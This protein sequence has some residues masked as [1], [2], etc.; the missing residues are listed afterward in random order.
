M[1]QLGDSLERLVTAIAALPDSPEPRRVLADLLLEQGH[2]LGELIQLELSGHFTRRWFDLV[3][4]H[5]PAFVELVAP[6]A[7]A[8]W[9]H[10]GLPEVAWYRSGPLL[11]APPS[12]LPFLRQVFVRASPGHGSTVLGHAALRHASSLVLACDGPTEPLDG[13]PLPAAL[14]AFT[15]VDADWRTLTSALATARPTLRRLRLVT[16][17]VE[18]VMAAVRAVLD[19]RLTLDELEL[20]GFALEKSA[21]DLGDAAKALGLS[22]LVL[23]AVAA[24]PDDLWR[25]EP[26]VLLARAASPSLA[27]VLLG[28]GVG[29]L[30]SNGVSS[31]RWHFGAPARDV[32]G[33]RL[34]AH[35]GSDF[36]LDAFQTPQ[37]HRLSLRP[38]PRRGDDPLRAQAFVR[39]VRAARVSSAAVFPQVRD[40]GFVEATPQLTLEDVRGPLLLPSCLKQPCGPSAALFRAAAALADGLGEALPGQLSADA[41]ALCDD[42]RL[43]AVSP[44]AVPPWPRAGGLKP[45]IVAV[46]SKE[47][48]HGTALTAAT[49]A[50]AL[51]LLIYVGCSGRLPQRDTSTPH[52]VL[53]ATVTDDF[54]PLDERAPVP[55]QLSA[56][57]HAALSGTLAVAEL[58]AALRA[59]ADTAPVRP[60]GPDALPVR[61]PVP[62]VTLWPSWRHAVEQIT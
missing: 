21:A 24:E 61:V 38:Q 1:K 29:G 8:A 51:A 44:F 18:P 12:R 39:E 2:P 49:H 35:L 22:Q 48:A 10:Q 6:N 32:D 19:A 52:A 16:T 46:L 54:V 7:D 25:F 20:D 55:T 14:Q 59:A 42:G 43:R 33:V 47:R 26:E 28:P 40:A 53:R 9:L 50:H 5:E 30:D 57:V 56:A 3:A 58:S 31:G 11:E 37:G 41:V 27:L 36:T 13:A 60:W 62:A 4:E 17:L 34:E 23:R 45:D 15:V